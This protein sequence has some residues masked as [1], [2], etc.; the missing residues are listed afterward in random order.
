MQ[1]SYITEL[2]TTGN[3]CGSKAR[4]DI[5]IILGRYYGN[6]YYVYRRNKFNSFFDKIKYIIKN[7]L[8][9]IK[10]FYCKNKSI[11]LQYPYGTNKI[12]NNILL[13]LSTHNRIILVIHDI[14][15]LRGFNNKIFSKEID[16][17]NTCQTVVLH[18][19]SMTKYMRKKG[20]KTHVVELE[21]F[22]YLLQTKPHSKFSFMRHISFAGNLEKSR[23][24]QDKKL[25]KINVTFELFGPG[26]S[27]KN[28][29]AKNI[30]YNGSY[31]EEEIPYH[32]KGGFGLVWDGEAIN[33]CSG[34]L[35]EY[36]KYNNP[37]KLSL[38]IAAGLPVIVWDQA[39]IADLVKKNNIGFVVG[40]LEEINDYFNELDENQYAEY[41]RNIKKLQK[42]VCEGEFFKDV[43]SKI[44]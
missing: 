3:R 43:L 1:Y 22:D 36:T 23:F 10:L 29:L 28:F 6:S 24:L 11:I 18:N 14:D 37:Y 32:L 15:S 38:Y 20:L 30:H 27:N 44:K 41:L 31:S 17:F 8:D 25:E 34:K 16:Y 12:L 7:S 26:Y 39:A 19:K 40:S 4:N 33:T 13:H 35:G 21:L 5:N 2:N 9:F 42:K